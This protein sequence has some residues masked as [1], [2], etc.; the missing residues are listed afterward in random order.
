M[1]FYMCVFPKKDGATAL[2]HAAG[3][4]HT[5]CVRLLLENGADKEEKDKVRMC[6]CTRFLVDL[7]VCMMHMHA[8]MHIHV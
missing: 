6:T 1:H 4:G 3:A 7:G 5:D 8:H 2:I